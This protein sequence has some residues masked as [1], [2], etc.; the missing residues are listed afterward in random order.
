MISEKLH[1]MLQMVLIVID[2]VMYAHIDKI[3]AILITT[4]LVLNLSRLLLDKIPQPQ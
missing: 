3:W 2:R 4:A 1:K